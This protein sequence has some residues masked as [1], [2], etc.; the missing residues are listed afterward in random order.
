MSCHRYTLH[1][2]DRDA[3]RIGL[4]AAGD[5]GSSVNRVLT[6]P[7]TNLPLT[8]RNMT[9]AAWVDRVEET[10]KQS[11]HPSSCTSRLKTSPESVTHD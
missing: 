5:D 10:G 6:V 11:D 3:E 1:V 8:V 7:V 4:S 9:E 2:R